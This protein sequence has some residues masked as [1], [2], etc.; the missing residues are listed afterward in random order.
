MNI[1]E[2]SDEASLVAK[3]KSDLV[4]EDKDDT[5]E[6]TD[7]SIKKQK[8]DFS[9]VDNTN[10]LISEADENKD[11]NGTESKK[12][13]GER[14]KILEEDEDGKAE[15]AQGGDED[16]EDEDEDEDEYEFDDSDESDDD[17]DDDDDDHSNGNAETV[18]RKGKGIMID[19]KGKGKMI[20]ESDEDSI[21]GGIESDDDDGDLSDDPL[22]E[23]DLDNILPTR[24][25]SRGRAVHHGVH[26]SDK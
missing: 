15:E 20:E 9:S 3:R 14:N 21:K 17:D 13:M 1:T 25:R 7:D 11:V 8:L 24:T 19:D 4:C 22:A 5:Q 23:V 12:A 16:N 26:I 18:D 10:P 2:V 6:K